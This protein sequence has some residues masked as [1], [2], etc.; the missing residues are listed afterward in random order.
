[1][2]FKEKNMTVLVMPN[3]HAALDSFPLRYGIS[4]SDSDKT[5]IDLFDC[6]DHKETHDKRLKVT[7]NFQGE[8]DEVLTGFSFFRKTIQ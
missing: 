8:D 3:E 4:Y 2:S 7:A 5:Q 1:M 6:K